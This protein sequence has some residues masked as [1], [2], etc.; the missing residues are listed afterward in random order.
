[1]S[2]VEEL[3]SQVLNLQTSTNS[4]FLLFSSAL[5]FLMI[6]AL[7]YFYSGLSRE[8]S[9][10]SFLL[11]C[12]LSVAVVFIEWY[13]WGYS[14]VFGPNSGPFIGNLNNA[15]LIGMGGGVTGGVNDFAYITFQGMF[16]SI[17]PALLLGATAERCRI[18]PKM[19]FVFIWSTVVYNVVAHWVWSTEGWL[20]QMGI[21]DFAGGLV[22]HIA[23][24]ISG[25]ACSMFIGKRRDM[26]D[27]P[28]S[29]SSVV[30]GTALLWF[31]WMG[32][33]GGSALSPNGQAALAFFNTNL[34]ACT[35]AISFMV[36]DYLR[37]HKWSCIAFCSGAVAG[38]VAITPGAGLVSPGAAVLFGVLSGMGTNIAIKMKFKLKYDD[39]LDVFGIHGIGGI[40]GS[41][42][43]GVFSENYYITL[44]NPDP[45]K[46]GGAIDG[47]GMQVVY[48]LVG[49]VAVCAYCFVLTYALLFIMD[50]IPKLTLRMTEDNE[51]DGIDKAEIGEYT[52]EFIGDRIN[53][54][55]KKRTNQIDS[56]HSGALEE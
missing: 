56:Y 1:M 8:K 9:G 22:V 37:H 12:F 28:H 16:A 55:D 35:A 45:T 40:I 13:V 11:L 54:N 44:G 50:K 19:V 21:Q 38:L 51:F 25:L 15:F 27:R 39:T 14:L 29:V 5:V 31:G 6:P 52:Y 48:Q 3:Q 4:S 7:G 2:S 18:L 10:L 32:F 41:I 36:L 42:L 20:F 34:A 46:T 49:T 26:Q 53:I 33:N 17:T 30:L 23:S 24:G 47:N 43:T